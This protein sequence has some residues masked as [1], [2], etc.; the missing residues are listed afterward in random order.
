MQDTENQYK[1]KER[2]LIVRLWLNENGNYQI[3]SSYP[4]TA[5]HPSY[6]DARTEAER[7]SKCHPGIPFGI[8]ELDSIA[9][10]PLYPVRWTKL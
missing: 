10:V 1:T 5:M 9:T 2:Y 8:F 4:P 3:N 7:L 6:L